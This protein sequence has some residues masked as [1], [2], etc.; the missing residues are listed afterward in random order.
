MCSVPKG[1]CAPRPEQD[2]RG[3]PKAITASK[4]FAAEIGRTPFQLSRK[5]LALLHHCNSLLNK[6]KDEQVKLKNAPGYKPESFPVII[7]LNLE[8]PEGRVEAGRS[9]V[10]I[11]T[12][13]KEVGTDSSQGININKSK[14]STQYVFASLEGDVIREL[15]KRDNAVEY[16]PGPSAIFHIWPDFKIESLINKSICTV[17]AGAAQTSFFRLWR[18]H[19]VGGA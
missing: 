14:Y 12:L 1:S 3:P 15:V 13:I 5:M 9:V 6:L 10:D 19:C 17:K 8:C 7:D 4:F 16:K 2:E 18:K 11:N